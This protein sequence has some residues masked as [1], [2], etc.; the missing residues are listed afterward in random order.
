VCPPLPTPLQVDSKKELA[1][2]LP[3]PSPPP[4]H[5]TTSSPPFPR[6]HHRSQTP[7]QVDSK[8]EL[9]K[10]LKTV[11]ESFIMALTKVAVE[12]MLSFIT[13]VVG[14]AGLLDYN[15]GGGLDV[16]CETGTFPQPAP[17]YEI[18]PVKTAQNSTF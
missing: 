7:P 14:E 13:K 4:P 11:C 18:S 15:H 8:K 10:Q 1:P 2:P 16:S 12:P 3:P 17:G 6:V 9:E 5:P